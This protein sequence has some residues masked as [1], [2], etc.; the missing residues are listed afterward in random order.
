MTDRRLLVLS[1]LDAEIMRLQH[2]KADYE[3][4]VP[5]ADAKERAASTESVAGE[6]ALSVDELG[7]RERA[8]AAEDEMLHRKLKAEQDRMLDGSI[9]TTREADALQHEIDN[10]TAKISELEDEEL[11]LMERREEL[12]GALVDAA[13]ARD[14]ARA[15]FEAATAS[16][17]AELAEIDTSL[18]DKRSA[19][20]AAT[21]GLD[22]E[23]LELYEE[24]RGTKHGIGA[25]ALVDGTCQGCHESLSS[26][27]VD[28]VVHTDEIAR[29]PNCRR[30]L[31]L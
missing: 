6:L 12:E 28:K 10:A 9:T 24:L 18:A 5:I 3:A 19:R 16:A 1:G 2:R 4:G 17:A 15:E 26:M 31:V 21:E 8:L 27:D 13:A 11:A 14:V 29:C 7:V 25:A 20:A 30:I 22:P 23:L